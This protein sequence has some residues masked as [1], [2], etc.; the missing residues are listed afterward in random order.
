MLEKII[1][2]FSRSIDTVNDR[3]IE[4]QLQK[5][6]L[7]E[8]AEFVEQN[9]IKTRSFPDKF[10]LLSYSLDLSKDGLFLEFGV[11]KGETINYIASKIDQI[12]YGF[13]S[14]E[15]LPEDWRDTF[16]KGAFK[17][18]KP[19]KVRKNV[20]LIKGLFE[21]TLPKF[22]SEN[23]ANYSFIHV[24]CD[25][26]SS[27]KTILENLNDKINE[28]TI[29]VFD[30]FFN[31]PNWKNGEYKAFFEFVNKNKIKFK[32]IGYCRYDEQVAIKILDSS[33]ND[34]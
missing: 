3:N 17:L 25:L 5:N 33:K 34:N 6:A 14:F 1:N 21:D 32:Y 20:K 11:F 9:M 31:H 22:I 10:S 2:L 4:R 15:G 24:D 28:G 7:K 8:T 29:I 27:T 16:K 19:P 30:E 12:V 13:D 26:Y 18:E 23:D